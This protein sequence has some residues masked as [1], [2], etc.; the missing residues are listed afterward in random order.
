[1]TDGVIWWTASLFFVGIRFLAVW[2]KGH[3][4][5][6]KSRGDAGITSKDIRIQDGAAL[7]VHRVTF[8]SQEIT[9][10]KQEMEEMIKNEVP[11]E[12]LVIFNLETGKVEVTFFQRQVC[13][14]LHTTQSVEVKRRT[15]QSSSLNRGM[16]GSHSGP[17]MTSTAFGWSPTTFMFIRRSPSILQRCSQFS[18]K[19]S[20]QLP[21]FL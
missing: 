11:R 3:F 21:S 6:E 5:K 2:H 4:A 7:E 15:N 16:A 14:Y 20:I 19:R 1:L 17:L 12:N 13:Y 8:T 18:L 9:K 10:E